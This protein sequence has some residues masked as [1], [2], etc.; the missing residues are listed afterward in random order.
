MYHLHNSL[1]I[2]NWE[3]KKHISQIEWIQTQSTDQL[4]FDFNL[5]S[6]TQIGN[7]ITEKTVKKHQKKKIVPT[8]FWLDLI[9]LNSNL[10]KSQDQDNSTWIQPYLQIPDMANLG[11]RL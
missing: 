8:T 10:N 9:W 7:E 1:T 11:L 5:K 4:K 6:L 2:I 3:P